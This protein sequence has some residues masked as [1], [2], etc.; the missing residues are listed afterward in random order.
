MTIIIG[1]TM[2]HLSRADV[3][4]LAITPAEIN[5][6][7]E[8]TFRAKA[9]GRA[10][11]R[12]KIYMRRPDASVFMAKAGALSEPSYA[13]IKW[14]GFIPGNAKRGFKDFHP[15]VLLSE[16]QTGQPVALMDGTWMTE[17]RTAAMS[18]VAAR[19]MAKP[20][21]RTIGFVACGIQ[22]RGHLRA[23]QA[24]FP[25]SSITAYSRRLETAEGFARW[26]QGEGVAARAVDDP[27]GAV[28][29]HDIVVTSVPHLTVG[30]LVLRGEWL[31][32][33]THVAMV[34]LGNSWNRSSLSVIERAVTDDMEQSGPGGSEKLNFEETRLL[35]DLADL[36]S[37]KIAGRASHE[38]RNAFIFSG[39]GLGDIGP[40][41]M[42]YE[43]ALAAG[44]GRVLPL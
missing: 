3:D 34:D 19:R 20:D 17:T 35:G 28:E 10:F 21:S 1:K 18:A 15:M 4:A 24:V 26:A 23:L 37:G 6:S 33:G 14:L 42:I 22:A 43:R 2:L 44:L 41:V 12:P 39:V 9:E 31:S 16:G 29:G 11:T 7:I 40:A 8:Q 36:V 5:E 32:P 30:D 27:R 25:I 13:C 38:E